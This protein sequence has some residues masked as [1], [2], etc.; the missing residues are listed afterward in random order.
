MA[1]AVKLPGREE[2]PMNGT[3]RP[4]WGQER[5]CTAGEGGVQPFGVEQCSGTAP[6]QS[7]H[8]PRLM[9]G[10]WEASS[11]G[12][13]EHVNSGPGVETGFHFS[14]INSREGTAGLYG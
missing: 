1:S 8:T 5:F 2:S 12:L 11:P 13:S 9:L 10:T 14:W 6:V 3:V 7:G 4:L